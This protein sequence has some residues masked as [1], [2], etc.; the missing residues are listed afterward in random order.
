MYA[1]IIV[2][3]LG[4]FGMSS[5]WMV[6]STVAVLLTTTAIVVRTQRIHQP[7]VLSQP[8]QRDMQTPRGR[9]KRAFMVARTVVS[10][11][12]LKRR[13]KFVAGARSLKF[14]ASAIKTQISS[15]RSPG[16]R[17]K[18]KFASDLSS[19]LDGRSSVR[20]QQVSG[21]FNIDGSRR[22]QRGKAVT[23]RS[24]PALDL[25]KRFHSSLAASDELV[26]FSELP[27]DSDPFD[28]LHV[29]V[30]APARAG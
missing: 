9:M 6:L 19:R 26:D 2:A 22:S 24:T 15:F 27:D 13:S 4:Y 12:L 20:L 30:R 8:D 3:I 11:R 21:K 17:V 16:T 28:R 29:W 14:S 23:F 25:R 18:Q 10:S 1:S 5:P 7:A